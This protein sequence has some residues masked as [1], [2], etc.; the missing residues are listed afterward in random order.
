MRFQTLLIVGLALVLSACAEKKEAT[1]APVKDAEMPAAVQEAE[2]PAAEGAPVATD[3]FIRHMHYHARQ[4]ERINVALAAGDLDAAQTPAYWLAAHERL[5][6]AADD[7]E[8]YINEMRDA[9][10]AVSEA[11]DLDTARAAT[12]RIAESCEGCHAHASVEIP[13]LV[14]QDE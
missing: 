8:P 7:W 14:L 6:G 4:L 5:E 2:K 1:P 3:S 12:D 13:T 11:P 10:R 9:A